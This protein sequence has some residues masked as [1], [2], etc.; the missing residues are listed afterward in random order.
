MPEFRF[1]PYCIGMAFN[2][3]MKFSILGI[4]RRILFI[5]YVPSSYIY[6]PVLIIRMY[7]WIIYILRRFAFFSNLKHDSTMLHGEGAQISQELFSV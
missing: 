4:Y 5:E 1:V 2:T 3:F 7:Y 6:I